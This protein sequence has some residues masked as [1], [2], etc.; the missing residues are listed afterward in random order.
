MRGARIA[1]LTKKR[2]MP[3]SVISTFFYIPSTVTL[4]IV[5][6]T[7]MVYD[8]LDV[9]QDVFNEMKASFSKGTFFNQHIKGVYDF[10][11]VD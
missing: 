10:R 2:I 6:V 8:Y 1:C 11:K 5:F 9:P 4:R 3:S 7:G